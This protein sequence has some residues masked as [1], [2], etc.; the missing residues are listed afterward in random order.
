LTEWHEVGLE[1]LP[2]VPFEEKPKKILRSLNQETGTTTLT[3]EKE[4]DIL[5]SRIVK[6]PT[7]I[8]CIHY[9]LFKV[10]ERAIIYKP[11][12]EITVRDFKTEKETTLTIDAITG[13]TATGL[14]QTPTPKKKENSTTPKKESTS[15]KTDTP[16]VSSSQKKN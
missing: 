11:M 8:F 6:R 3:A 16:K 5:K 13:K 10:S 4:V 14:P 15:K 1:D 2:L 9:E 12:Y 7:E